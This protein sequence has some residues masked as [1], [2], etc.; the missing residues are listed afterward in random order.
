MQSEIKIAMAD[1]QV[2]ICNAHGGALFGLSPDAAETFGKALIDTAAK[3][4][5]GK[6]IIE[7][8]EGIVIKP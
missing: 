6:S 7:V 2:I 5:T 1:G 3:I 4:K 8:P